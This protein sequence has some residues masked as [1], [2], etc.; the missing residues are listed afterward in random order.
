MRAR[1]VD[2][3]TPLGDDH[4]NQWQDYADARRRYRLPGPY[5]VCLLLQTVPDSS[6]VHLVFYDAQVRP[7]LLAKLPYCTSTL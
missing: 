3:L 6:L 7:C 1:G 5:V 4:C 2:A